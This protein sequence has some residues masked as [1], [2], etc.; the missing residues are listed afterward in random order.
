[1]FLRIHKFNNNNY[2]KM[3]KIRAAKLVAP[4]AGWGWVVTFG[5]SIINVS[6]AKDLYLILR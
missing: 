4:D 1:M 5:V 6:S 2:P 3:E